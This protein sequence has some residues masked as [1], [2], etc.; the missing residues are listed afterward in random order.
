MRQSIHDPRRADHGVPAG[1]NSG[2]I[3]KQAM[4]VYGDRVPFRFDR[5]GK[6]K[7]GALPNGGEDGVIFLR[8]DGALD[9]HRPAAPAA[10]EILQLTEIHLED[11]PRVGLSDGLRGHKFLEFDAL[12]ERVRNLL[13]GSRHVFPFT[14]VENRHFSAHPAAAPGYVHRDIASADDGHPFSRI[15]GDSPLYFSQILRASFHAR[16]ILAGNAHGETLV[17]A[18]RDKHR[19]VVFLELLKRDVAS[20]PGIGF[21]FHAHA[22]EKVDFLIENISGE[23]IGR[24]PVTEHSAQL[25]KLLKDRG[26]IS[27]QRQTVRRGQAARSAADNGDLFF[28]R[29]TFLELDGV[30]PSLRHVDGEPFDLGDVQRLIGFRPE[31]DVRAGMRADPAADTRERI[32]LIDKR[33]R[34]LIAPLSH[35]REVTR[36]ILA[37][38]AGIDALRFVKLYAHTGRASL[39]EDMIL[40]FMAKV[41]QCREHRVGGG[42]TQ[43]AERGISCRLGEL[44]EKPDVAL[45]SLSFADPGQNLEHLPDALAA[46][47]AFAA[48]FGGKEIEKILRDIDHAGVFIHHDHAARA[49]DG[50]DFGQLV[51]VDFRIQILRGNAASRRTARLDRLELLAIGNAAAQLV[52]DVSQG[53][54]HG[55]FHE[56]GMIHL[57]DE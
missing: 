30:A 19:I 10:V 56:A 28:L 52:D 16:Q 31:A 57:A 21:D 7:I 51:E 44:H 15:R 4:A 9:G 53:D 25:R 23:T 43:S 34:L 35:Q 2:E 14:P 13:F 45:P 39:V 54:A 6:L 1:K 37:D 47:G 32:G 33:D 11:Q 27:H 24:N 48:R 38:R 8:D 18:D 22:Y 29:L 50:A 5:S 26:P 36:D 41:F 20:D 55:D 42:S 12:R 17:S 46:W 49:H 3:G 40:V